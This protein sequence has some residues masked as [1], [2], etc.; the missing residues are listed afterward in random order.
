MRS[1]LWVLVLILFTLPMVRANDIAGNGNGNS[2]GNPGLGRGRKKTGGYAL[3]IVGDYSGTGTG[4]ITATTVSISADLKAPDGFH[5]T[6]S[7][8]GMPLVNDR[9]QGMTAFKGTVFTLS[10]RVDLPAATDAEQ[11][12]AQ[13]LTGRVT[14]TL[15]GAAGKGARLVAIQDEAARGG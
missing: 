6:L 15:G 3:V 10:G 1:W 5:V 7:F 13:A 8:G 4:S 2:N 11:T 12:P 9:F 14:A